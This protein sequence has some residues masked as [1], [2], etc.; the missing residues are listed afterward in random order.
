MIFEAT[1]LKRLCLVVI[2]Y[3]FISFMYNIKA[4]VSKDSII[5][6]LLNIISQALSDT[7]SVFLYN[8]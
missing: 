5:A 2:G 6:D 4:Q 8:P 1:A 7:H 3:K